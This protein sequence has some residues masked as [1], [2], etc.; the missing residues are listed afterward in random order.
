M[1]RIS[2]K[3]KFVY[4]APPKTG[5][6]TI[7]YALNEYSEVKSIP[8]LNSPLYYHVKPIQLENYFEEQNWNWGE[9]F[10]FALVRNPFDLL[11]SRYFWSRDVQQLESFKEKSF[12]NCRH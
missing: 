6:T 9:Y 2:H 12:S 4:I 8:Y 1:M 11:V 7:R 10:K 5:S 3:H